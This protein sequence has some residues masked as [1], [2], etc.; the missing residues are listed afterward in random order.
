MAGRRVAEGGALR[1]ADEVLAPRAGS[2]GAGSAR[3]ALG[4]DARPSRLAGFP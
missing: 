2:A 1:F 4:A 3:Q